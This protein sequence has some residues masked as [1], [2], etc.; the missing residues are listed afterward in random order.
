MSRTEYNLKYNTGRSRDN[1]SST[2]GYRSSR[3]AGYKSSET[4]QEASSMAKGFQRGYRKGKGNVGDKLIEG[5]IEAVTP[6]A[7]ED[8]RRIQRSAVKYI[9]D[10]RKKQSEKHSNDLNKAISDMFK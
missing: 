5:M 3:R 4:Y 7:D 10:P 8:T 9:L 2:S 1:S 6:E